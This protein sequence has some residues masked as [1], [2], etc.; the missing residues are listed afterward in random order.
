MKRET[1]LTFLEAVAPYDF[2][3][4]GIV[5]N[6][7]PKVLYGEGFNYREPF[8]KY[9]TKLVFNTAKPYLSN[10]KV[11]IDGSGDREFKRSFQ[12][13]LKRQINASGTTHIGK[14]EIQRSHSNNLLQLADMIAGALQ[15]SKRQDK[16]DSQIYRDIIRMREFSVQE[17]PR[18]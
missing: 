15:R 13:Y 1:R 2:S 3:Y 10:A 16:A 12:A 8:Y 9:A 18:K 11:V 14:V 4:F 6:K 5:I 17:W 7:D